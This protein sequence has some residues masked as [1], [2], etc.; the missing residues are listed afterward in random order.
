M[1][2]PSI[3]VKKINE[4]YDGFRYLDAYKMLLPAWDMVE[5]AEL[6]TAEELVHVGRLAGRLGNDELRL[7]LYKKANTVDPENPLVRF[8]AAL[9]DREF[10]LLKELREYEKNPAPSLVQPEWQ[11]IWLTNYA[12]IFALV[13]DFGKAGELLDKARDLGEEEAWIDCC[14]ADVLYMEDRWDEALAVAERAWKQ[15]PGMPRGAAVLGK[16]LT[17]MGRLDE[18]VKTLLAAAQ[19]TQSHETLVTTLWH[20]CVKAERSTEELRLKLAARAYELSKKLPRLAPIADKDTKS[21]IGA[22]RMDIAVLLD[23]TALMKKHALETDSPYY[24]EIMKNIEKNRE[25]RRFVL[26]FRL[27]FQKHQTCLPASVAAVMGAFGV[28]IDEDELASDLTYNGTST[29]RTAEW[30]EARGFQ[31]RLFVC[32]PD[33]ARKLIQSKLPFVLLTKHVGFAHASAAVGISAKSDTLTVHDPSFERWFNYLIDKIDGDEAPFGPEGMAIVPNEKAALLDLIPAESHESAAAYNSYIKLCETQGPRSGAGLV[34][35][36]SKKWPGLPSARRLEA[37][38]LGFTGDIFG[39]IDIQKTLLKDYP[40]NIPLRGE[41]LDN[42]YKL[43]NTALIRKVL[44]DIV[45]RGKM[46]GISQDQSWRYPPI[47]YVAQYADFIGTTADGYKKAEKALEEALKKDMLNSE[48]YHILGD[49]WARQGRF[50]ESILPFRCASF[51]DEHNEHYAREVCETLRRANRENE[52]LQFLAARVKKLGKTLMGSFPWITLIDALEDYGFPDKAIAMM[53]KART[54]W[55]EDES[56]QSHAVRFWIRMGRWDLAAEALKALETTGNTM[57]Y[58]SAAVNYYRL[59]GQWEKAFQCC[60][61]WIAESPENMAARS[62]YVSLYEMGRGRKSGLA[63]TQKWMAEHKGNDHFE[64]LHYDELKR[65]YRDDEQIRILTARIKRNRHDVWAWREYGFVMMSKVENASGAERDSHVARFGKIVENCLRLAPDD[66]ST[67]ALRAGYEEVRGNP[68]KAVNL[69][70][71]AL[72]AEPEYAYCYSKIW[73]CAES[74]TDTDQR[75]VLARLEKIM[76]R[77]V[78]FLH[79]ARDLAFK[80][81]ERFG[82]KEAD[83]YIEKWQKRSPN[84]P[85]IIEARADLLLHYGQGKSDAKIAAELLEDAVGRFPNQFDLRTSLAHAYSVLQRPEDEI[86]VLREII[87]RNPLNAMARNNLANVMANAG[88]LDDAAELLARGIQCDPQEESVP[89]DLAMLFWRYGDPEQA[90][91]VLEEAIRDIPESIMLRMVFVDRLFDLGEDERAVG[92]AKEGIDHYP[93]GAYLWY[94]YGEAL[95]RSKSHSDM[96]EI[97]SVYRKA[98]EFNPAYFDPAESLAILLSEQ[99]LFDDAREIIRRQIPLLAEPYMGHGRL[100]CITRD[101]GQ[102]RPAI[103]EMAEVIQKWPTYKW[104]WK[105]LLNWLGEDEEWELAKNFLK[106]V[107][108]VMSDDPSFCSERLS[109]L[110]DAGIPP[111]ELD[112]EWDGLLHDFPTNEKIICQRI[113]NLFEREDWRKAEEI[114]ATAES[115]RRL[116][117]YMMARK[118][119]LLVRLM[120]YPKAVECALDLWRMPGDDEIWPEETA[121]ES[122]ADDGFRVILT[123]ETMALVKKGIRIRPRAFALMVGN[124]ELMHTGKLTDSKYLFRFLLKSEIAKT[125]EELPEIIDRGGYDDTGHYKSVALEKFIDLG[126]QKRAEKYWKRHGGKSRNETPLWQTMGRI[127]ATGD[128]RDMRRVRNHMADWRERPG[129]EM[130]AVANYVNSLRKIERKRR[131]PIS[132]DLNELYATSKDA[133]ERLPY[134]H[135]VKYIACVLCESA[136]RLGKDEAFLEFMGR[137]RPLILSDDEDLWMRGDYAWV[138]EILDEFTEMMTCGDK[139]RIIAQS[140]KFRGLLASIH[141]PHLMPWVKKEWLGRVKKKLPFGRYLLMRIML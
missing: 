96:T 90:I 22:C 85:E 66:P 72:A 9:P 16:I 55:P 123:R 12:W 34:G 13:R 84:D 41:L 3:P 108:P 97:E 137:F 131:F 37:I 98:L 64:K 38:H 67:L 139:A 105:I 63:L 8:L 29:W 91:G 117:S 6:G 5:R 119:F 32:T 49:I 126:L 68:K 133:L 87:R 10:N 124:I 47:T 100:A 76:L 138:P 95:V 141:K 18:A 39:A 92:T 28:K 19:S 71:K 121:W 136:L 26:P 104:G 57:K 2:R 60:E 94:Q 140:K 46:P 43:R 111:G 20:M 82:V 130:W 127:Y 80:I 30:L 61:K 132:E 106:D 62:E 116:T 102:K 65:R 25:S 23:D 45:E 88:E 24:E 11:A 69:L 36:F 79:Q 115:S 74:F 73:N 78:G 42:L 107:H 103:D 128:N 129:C 44:E 54:Q 50:E 7:K 4:L 81:A 120:H 110:H 135:T 56:L 31:T 51:L 101:E 33:L 53:Q 14:Q 125:I 114:L 122:L 75:A 113:D 93:D 86:A 35:D 27:V 77:I 134:D 15:A 17:K 40:D 52:G 112:P 70:L 83:K 89:R 21:R 118:I 59:S 58:L 99:R 48:A 1:N 109:L